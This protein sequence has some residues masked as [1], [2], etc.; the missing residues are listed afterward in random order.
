MLFEDFLN[1]HIRPELNRLSFPS[2]IFPFFIILGILMQVVLPIFPILGREVLPN[3]PNVFRAVG[4]TGLGLIG[5]SIAVGCMWGLLKERIRDGY[6]RPNFGSAFFFYSVVLLACWFFVYLFVGRFLYRY[7]AQEYLSYI[8]EVSPTPELEAEIDRL[9]LYEVKWHT[10]FDY[11]LDRQVIRYDLLESVGGAFQ[12]RKDMFFQAVD[13]YKDKE[14]QWIIDQSEGPVSIA[15]EVRYPEVFVSREGQ[16][17]CGVVLN[18]K[19][20]RL[21]AENSVTGKVVA[22]EKIENEANNGVYDVSSVFVPNRAGTTCFLRHDGNKLMAEF[23]VKSLFL[24]QSYLNVHSIKVR[25]HTHFD[26]GNKHFKAAIR[27][28]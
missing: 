10:P 6:L 9:G 16:Y 25:D 26:F 27:N 23:F 15:L 19:I 20:E 7:P 18:T 14:G 24:P 5:G 21:L 1:R 3:W 8:L 11:S 28:L 17:K 2:R 22:L 4:L 13:H 12:S